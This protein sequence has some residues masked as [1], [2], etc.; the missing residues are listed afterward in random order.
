MIEAI[1]AAAVLMVVVARRA[2]GARHRQPQLRPREG[3]RRRRGAH[4]AGPGAP[5][6]VPRRRSR[7]LRPDAHVKVNKITYTI[8]SKAEWVRDST[9]G[10]ESC[11][12]ST[13]PGRLHAGRRRRRPRAWSPARSRRSRCRASSPPRSAP[14]APTRAR[15]ASRSTTATARASPASR[16]RSPGRRRVSNPTNSVGLRDLRLRPRRELHR[17]AQRDRLGRPGRQRDEPS[18]GADG[19]RRRRQRDDHDLRPRGQR[20]GQLRHRDAPATASSPPSRRSVAGSNSAVPAGPFSPVAGLRVVGPR[21]GAPA[22]SIDATGAVPLLGRLR[23]VRR[24]LP[25]RRPDEHDQRH[26]RLL[27]HATRATYV[28]PGAGARRPAD[29]AAAALDQ[30]EGAPQRR[31]DPARQPVARSSSPRRAPRGLLAEKFSLNAATDVERLDA[32]RP[33]LPFGDYQVCVDSPR[34]LPLRSSINKKTIRWQQHP[35]PQAGRHPARA[36]DRLGT[37]EPARDLSD[38]NACS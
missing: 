38:R 21:R 36:S 24:R 6:L 26:R 10:T 35:E 4:R 28:E 16:S 7:Q 5:A 30:P 12:S 29:H 32:T 20:R 25:R 33:A 15:S 31:S 23:H 11:N 1:I 9:G 13:S 37:G 19:H 2:Q 18:K 22:A 27:R 3:T 14:S 8:E 34:L 17:H